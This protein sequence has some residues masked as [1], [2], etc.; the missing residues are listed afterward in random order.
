MPGDAYFYEAWSVLSVSSLAPLAA[1]T[2]RLAPCCAVLEC[3]VVIQNLSCLIA[4]QKDRLPHLHLHLAT[5][6]NSQ[7]G[8]P[9]PS[10]IHH[11]EV[12]EQAAHSGGI[13]QALG[14]DDVPLWFA[15]AVVFSDRDR[16]L[17]F[18]N[19]KPSPRRQADRPCLGFFLLAP[20]RISFC[21][22]SRFCCGHDPYHPAGMGALQEA[23]MLDLSA[24]TRIT[25]RQGAECPR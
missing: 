5:T 19:N 4:K 1:I 24:A 2:P 20:T 17:Y 3:C 16:I 13:G 18:V 21:H 15:G 23:R 25:S 7:E 10:S 9:G 8:S 22:R 12:S 11:I 14:L 6:S